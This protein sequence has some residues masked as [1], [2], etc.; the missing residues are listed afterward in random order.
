MTGSTLENPGQGQGLAGEGWG[1]LAW[2]WD[3]FLS[4][5]IKGTQMVPPVSGLS[6]PHP[7]RAEKF[8]P[9]EYFYKNNAEPHNVLYKL[10][11]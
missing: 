7:L 6:H 2:Q 3:G 11:K 1:L 9:S 10:V 4:L 5:R 8:T